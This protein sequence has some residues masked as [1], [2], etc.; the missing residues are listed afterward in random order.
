MD[1]QYKSFARQ[2]PTELEPCDKMLALAAWLRIN[3]DGEDPVAVVSWARNQRHDNWVETAQALR[4]QGLS[5]RQI[6]GRCGASKS[7][8]A[9]MIKPVA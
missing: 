8:V 3:L 6:A 7:S 2:L 9:R 1:E 5:V 4:K